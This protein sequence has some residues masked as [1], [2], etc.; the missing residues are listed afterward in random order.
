MDMEYTNWRAKFLEETDKFVNQPIIDM[1]YV[2]EVLVADGQVWL[3]VKPIT[4]DVSL[5]YLQLRE[6]ISVTEML[7]PPEKGASVLLILATGTASSGYVLRVDDPQYNSFD[8][9]ELKYSDIAE[10]TL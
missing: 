2:E 4:I 8:Y 10:I 3:K 5:P 1:A 7:G 6:H 9:W